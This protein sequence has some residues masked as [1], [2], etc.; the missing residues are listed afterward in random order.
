MTS[1]WLLTWLACAPVRVEPPAGTLTVVQ[2]QQASWVRNFNPYAV[3]GSSRW[4]TSAGIYEPLAIYNAMTSE[5]VP[6]L[7]TEWAWTDPLTLD[8][9]LRPRVSWSDGESLTATDVVFSFELIHRFPALDQQGV[10]SFLDRVEATGDH[11]LTFHLARP[12]APGMGDLL[13]LP[14]VPEHAWREVKD[15]VSFS[16]PEPV[17]SGPYTEIGRFTSQSWTLLP[18]ENWWGGKPGLSQIRFPALSSNDQVTL[19]L[20]EGVVDWAGAFVP[21]VDRT[22]V[23]RDPEHFHYWFPA[24]GGMVFL[25]PNHARPPFDD[26]RVRKAISLALDREQLVDVA[27]YG[28]TDPAHA[29]GLSSAFED[30]RTGAKSAPWIAHDP[31]RAGELLTEA[32]LVLGADGLRRDVDGAILTV[33]VTAV[34]GWSDWVR[35]AQVST[36]MLREVGIEATL[37]TYDFGA[38]FEKVQ[39]GEF[40]LTVG[41]SVEGAIPYAYYK[42]LMSSHTYKPVGEAASA[43]WH[44]FA[45]PDADALLKAFDAA[46]DAAEQT[47]LSLK[48]QALFVEH[49]PAVPLFANPSWGE[50]NTQRIVGFPTPEDPYARLSPNHPPESLLVLSRLRAR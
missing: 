20:I 30:L 44:R 36:R 3:G 37:R 48:L 18:N 26:A 16:N 13:H 25:Y 27:M 40:D 32:G 46:T 50:A 33:E 1:W 2:E 47:A 7:A 35:A 28:Y 10:W 14:I 43:N 38:W 41:W 42:N 9:R 6:W 24:L 15:P 22:Y 31:V 23:A 39:R 34:A 29:T 45:H 5:W 49:A 21:A 8:V 4:P 17:A 19:A 12:Q 11:A